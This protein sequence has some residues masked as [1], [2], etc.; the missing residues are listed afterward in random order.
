MPRSSSASAF[1]GA[2]RS[3]RSTAVAA[4]STRSRCRRRGGAEDPG[5]RPVRI[6]LQHPGQILQRLGVAA[7]RAERHRAVQHAGRGRP[8]SWS[9]PMVAAP[10]AR[11]DWFGHHPGLHRLGE[12]RRPRRG[13]A[14][15]CCGPAASSR[16]A[17][18]SGS[19]SASRASAPQCLAPSPPWAASQ[20]SAKVSAPRPGPA[21][22]WPRH[23][24][25]LRAAGD[26]RD[27]GRQRQGLA[28]GLG[29]RAVEQEQP[30]AGRDGEEGAGGGAEQDGADAR[31]VR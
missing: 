16:S 6:R 10:K 14:R 20:L 27:V 28:S 22:A 15:R 7:E 9:A 26:A 3:A 8:A 19:P 2:S 13:A 31:H 1:S 21:A 24:L 17:A 30:R 25:V 29:F 5:L 18:C 23:S 12:D 4:W 11:P